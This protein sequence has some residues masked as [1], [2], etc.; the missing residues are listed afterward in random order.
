MV[1]VSGSALRVE[2]I[3]NFNTA[4]ACC[5]EVNDGWLS[6]ILDLAVLDFFPR[7]I[8][9][10]LLSKCS[11]VGVTITTLLVQKFVEDGEFLDENELIGRV[12]GVGEQRC[13]NILDEFRPAA[14][15]PV[16]GDVEKPDAEPEI[17]ASE[18]VQGG[19]FFVHNVRCKLTNEDN[20]EICRQHLEKA[21]FP[22]MGAILEFNRSAANTKTPFRKM[23]DDSGYTL[24]VLTLCGKYQKTES[25]CIF[26]KTNDWI[27][28]EA[29]VLDAWYENDKDNWRSR[30]FGRDPVLCHFTKKEKGEDTGAHLL[31]STFHLTFGDRKHLC[32]LDSLALL[33]QALGLSGP[34]SIPLLAAGDGNN[35]TRQEVFK[36][37][38]EGLFSL[39]SEPTMAK[40][41]NCYDV[42]MTNLMCS[43]EIPNTSVLREVLTPGHEGVE[44]YFRYSDHLALYGK[45]PWLKKDPCSISTFYENLERRKDG[46]IFIFSREEVI[47]PP[48]PVI[49]AS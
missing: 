44:E 42:C 16:V 1:C 33:Y 25:V 14:V 31:F 40:T 21:E 35:G 46:D 4:L 23:M 38:R 3:H 19:T 17:V 20:V 29:I 32:E 11:G 9:A 7:P 27:L 28:H 24:E 39:V 45:V 5:K 8:T 43:W 47:P 12:P 10:R 26:Y 15:E 48:A 22:S 36:P 18:P 13:R 41:D 34:G 37:N 49:P 30:L 6:P 2:E